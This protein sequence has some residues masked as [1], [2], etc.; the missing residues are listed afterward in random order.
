MS[1][2]WIRFF[3]ACFF[4]VSIGCSGYFAWGE[5]QHARACNEFKIIAG[6]D[7]ASGAGIFHGTL[8]A[9][10]AAFDEDFGMGAQNSMLVRRRVEMYQQPYQGKNSN[11][12]DWDDWSD[13]LRQNGNALSVPA[14]THYATNVHLGNSVLS[15]NVLA[16]APVLPLPPRPELPAVLVENEW[17]VTDGYIYQGFGE[18]N[19]PAIGD[20]RIQF[21]HVPSG[22]YS[23]LGMI[24]GGEIHA[25]S[26]ANGVR[27]AAMGQGRLDIQAL[28][29]LEANVRYKVSWRSVIGFVLLGAFGALLLFW[30]SYDIFSATAMGAGLS[31]G[32][33]STGW[34]AHQPLLLQILLLVV[35]VGAIVAILVRRMRQRH[36][37]NAD[38]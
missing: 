3:G 21:E 33:F 17:R 31:A 32:V 38:H 13:T 34:V 2:S 26:A 18:L 22:P 20:L 4:L 8:F 14:A 30:P 5:I 1:V 27:L 28:L 11:F 6:T 10:E 9:R 12:F 35:A 16:T 36:F 29:A 25:F 15:Q 19:S 23:A 7:V 37:A 24:E